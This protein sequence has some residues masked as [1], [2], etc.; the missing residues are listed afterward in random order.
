M[1]KIVIAVIVYNRVQNIEKWIHCWK[2]CNYQNAQ[3]VIIDNGK[4]TRVKEMCEGVATYIPRNNIGFDIGAF[5]DVCRNR[6]VGFPDYQYLLWCTDDTFPMSKDFVLPY[7][8]HLT[9][10]PFVGI[11]C[12]KLS[13]S[14]QPHVRTTGFMISKHLAQK[15]AFPADPIITKQQCYDFEHK[16]KN[17]MTN[18]VRQLG[19]SCDQVLPDNAAPMWDAGYWKRL[20][21]QDEFERVFNIENKSSDKV[22]FICTIYNT[23]PQIISSLTLQTHHNWKLILI[24]DGPSDMREAI[25][26]LILGDPRITFIETKKRINNWGHGLRQKAINEYDLGDYV[27]ITNAD[28]YYVPTFVEYMLK[29]FKKS[30]T[31]VATYCEKMTHSYKAWDV[32]NC[33]L[34]KGYLDCGCVMVKSEVA[35]EVGWS[36]I[37]EHSADWIYFSEI[38][39]KYSWKNFIPVKGNLFTHN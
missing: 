29:G 21:R 11:A 32:I 14:V 27:V 24:H 35:K 1:K 20:D 8:N 16:G 6:L 30:H 22:V 37:T 17:T 3:L 19:L 2:Q 9:A 38:A 18:Q 28:N 10:S 5:Q 23:Y 15:L 13:F 34:E 26:N 31:A 25:Q 33:K 4:S 12:M 36:N 7:I 39:N